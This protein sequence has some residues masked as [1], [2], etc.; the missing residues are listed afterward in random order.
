MDPLRAKPGINFQKRLQSVGQQVA[1]KDLDGKGHD[2]LKQDLFDISRS[3]LT[4][5]KTMEP[6]RQNRESLA[7]LLSLTNEVSVYTAVAAGLFPGTGVALAASVAEKK[8]DSALQ[9]L[10]ARAGSFFANSTSGATAVESSSP[11][12]PVP[13]EW[14]AVPEGKFLF[15]PDK[16]EV[17]LPAYK[18][19]KYPVTN[20]D[21][22]KFVAET[23]Y[24]TQGNWQP[25]KDGYDK[26]DET[27]EKPCVH[28]TFHDANAYAKWAG[29]RLPTEQEW[30]KAAR[31]DDGRLYPWGNEW[32][33]NACN[34]EG[35]G[36]TPVTAFE[37]AGNVSPYGAVDMVG[38]AMEWVDSGAARRPGA[39]LLKGGAW[40][41]YRAPNA[42]QLSDAFGTVR[43]TSEYP[44][45]SY[46]GFGF[47]IVTDQEVPISSPS[48]SAQNDPDLSSPTMT[49]LSTSQKTLDA[50]MTPET[51][52]QPMTLAEQVRLAVNSMK[53]GVAEG[54]VE[55]PQESLKKL[56]ALA[57]ETRKLRPLGGSS[58]TQETRKA[59]AQVHAAANRIAT[60]GAALSTGTLPPGV[61]IAVLDSHQK[62]MVESTQLL[63]ATPKTT[64][65]GGG[66]KPADRMFDWVEVPGGKAVVGRHDE[67]VEID[68]FELSKHPVTNDQ[69]LEFVQSTDYEMEGGWRPPDEG[70]FLDRKRGKEPVVNVSFFD[71]KAFC[72]WAGCRLPGE[73]E[74]EK[75]ARGAD[76]Q[77]NSSQSEFNPNGQIADHGVIRAVD[78]QPNVTPYGAEGMIGN[79]LEW[80]E[81]TSERRPGSVLL[82]GGAWSNGGFKPFT[83]ERHSTDAPNSSYGGFG[84]R[85]AR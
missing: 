51:A 75:A 63:E 27:G 8:A 44:D 81:G 5:Y 69:F 59:A 28:V 30:E 33:P 29:G 19:S 67:E 41:N 58:D 80:V 17:D 20:R 39:V 74:W 50:G 54:Q 24:K 73:N 14:V 77:H 13:R 82:K 52:G 18:I 55:I 23:G 57:E 79:V 15:G 32:N 70:V 56:A 4:Q 6:T 26:S 47:R 48:R 31:G 35:S 36:L 22:H 84:F 12:P 21:F 11:K 62:T 37:K 9:E 53:S 61:A 72:E 7:R 25:P 85:V 68:R 10:N 65:A 43:Q 2:A 49:A 66:P 38:N 34:N 83:A 78:D 45:S 40:Q 16:K 76:G 71:A 64:L 3:A 46:A 1:K 60:L 42:D